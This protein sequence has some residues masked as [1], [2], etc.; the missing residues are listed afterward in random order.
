M[1]RE[2]GSRRRR[3][4]L[5]L[6]IRALMMKDHFSCGALLWKPKKVTCGSL[7]VRDPTS[8]CARCRLLVCL[9]CTPRKTT[10][11]HKEKVSNE[12]KG[13]QLENDMSANQVE[14]CEEESQRRF[15][16]ERLKDLLQPKAL[17]SPLAGHDFLF[18][19]NR[20][21]FTNRRKRRKRTPFFLKK[22]LI[23]QT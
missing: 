14:S 8:V 6:S 15:E 23:D 22:R 20:H 3:R 17:R 10:T 5:L 1:G 11:T 12:R 2:W 18:F 9:T 13:K 7:T 4:P 19:F 16:C 21:R